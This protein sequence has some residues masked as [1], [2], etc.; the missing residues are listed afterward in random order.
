MISLSPSAITTL[1]MCPKKYYLSYILG[2][3]PTE[4]TESQRMGTLWH[5][6]LH[7]LSL[8]EGDKCY[9][10]SQ[11]NSN[12]N[13]C[14]ICSGDGVFTGGVTDALIKFL[15][16]V[17]DN[18]YTSLDK[19][20][21]SIE[22]T[23]LL[24][25]ALAYNWYY[26]NI[27][28]NYYILKAEQKFE[29][30]L[31]NPITKEAINDCKLIGIVDKLI[32][33]PVTLT[34]GIKEHKST[35]NTIDAQ[36]DYWSHLKLDTQTMFY[37]YAIIRL[38]N[39]GL[40][41]IDEEPKLIFYDVW[42][43]P[44]LSPKKITLADTKILLDTGIYYDNPFEV[45]REID[46]GNLYING[47]RVEKHEAKKGFYITESVDMFGARLL[48]ELRSNLEGYFIQKPIYRT[49]EDLEWFEQ[50]LYNIY[51]SIKLLSKTEVW[52]HNEWQCE[53]M[54]KCQYCLI[55]YNK[56]KIDPNQPA[57]FGFKFIYQRKEI[58]GNSK[59]SSS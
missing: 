27:N 55:C 23:I 49:S 32:V 44:K 6:C 30:L 33:D 24:Y 13:D 39:A 40:L 38:K 31:I 46:G 15:N 16:S 21:A 29:L 18:K 36:S 34:C 56:M 9:V 43:K 22:R 42:H 14:Y 3:R 2:L 20:K 58:D 28:D 50:E 41:C 1:K 5:E 52:Y 10:C 25:S 48:S 57:P 47:E 11:N 35:S 4:D 53:N 19:N 12:N 45:K 54:G 51:L 7:I 59:S 17:Y 37:L 26:S 8:K